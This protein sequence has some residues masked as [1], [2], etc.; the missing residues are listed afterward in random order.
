MKKLL[1]TLAVASVA[2][3]SSAATRVLY[4]QNFETVASPADAGWTFGGTSLSIAS[5]DA[6]KFLELSLGG[7]NGR[8]GIVTW[9][10][11]IFLKDGVS[12]LE[13]GTYTV[14]F[15]F[16]IKQGSNNQYNSAFTVF[17]NHKPTDNQ[18]YRNPWNPAGWWDNYLFDMSQ[19]DKQPLQF[20]VNGKTIE[21]TGDDGTVTR[22]ID[23]ST[24]STFEQ[25]QWYTVTLNVDVNTREVEYSVATFGMGDPV[26]DASGTI[27]VPENDVNG[28]PINMF[29]Q[30][31]F[32]MVARYQTIYD[33]DNIKVFYESASDYA[34]APTLALTRL[35]R[36][37]EGD[38][39]L[40]LR[41]YTITF[42]EGETLHVLGTDGVETAVEY[43]DPETPGAY[44]YEATE[45]GTLKAWTTSGE[46]TSEVVETEVDCN[47]VVLPQATATIS[48]VTA[49]FGKTYTLNVD[50]SDVPLRPTIFI[51]YEFT[52]KSGTVISKEGEA[53]GCKIT[54]DEEGTL[55]ITTQSFGY[56]EN[57]ASVV[58]DLEFEVKKMYDF[59]R[60]GDEEITKAGFPAWTVLNTSNMSGFNSWSGRK[61]LYYELA[62]SEHDNGEGVMIR[63][64]VYPFG[65]LADDNTTN[66]IKYAVI[67]N[68]AKESVNKGDVFEGLT[69]FPDKGR[70]SAGFPNVGMIRG[71][72]L[73][74]DQTNNNNNNIIV[75]D[76]DR[77]DFVVVNYINNY[78]GNSIHPVCAND[79]EYFKQL[80]GEDAVYSVAATGVLDEA[81]QT[82]S[83]THALYRVDT[84]CTK[85]TVFKQAGAQSGLEN[86]V[87]A[88]EENTDEGWYT[89]TGLRLEK[90]TA[91]GLYIHKGKKVIVK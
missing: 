7:S 74:N 49:G 58:N 57:T 63:D 62:G 13:D 48:S 52:G 28:D 37:A 86:V 81:S 24:P 21:T 88:E 70:L 14:Q 9:G 69:I 78:G 79:E 16:C 85:I 31:L 35:G 71:I 41:A 38:L 23:Y 67:D 68:S 8:S 91:P 75:N 73:Y 47:P 19:V 40:N 2:L 20:A 17:T 66:V 46:A 55:K 11:D 27:T 36:T 3:T 80:A 12:V 6:G 5:D 45:S 87:V 29:A 56:Q 89:I 51:N 54:V 61:R 59:A 82:Y 60:M 43:Y 34:N 4:E 90:P 44:V 42:L 26:S 30:G 22:A 77:N 25:N 53:S 65:Y 83:Q 18:P 15:D 32:V 33:I 72:G 84:A 76:L 64:L 39:N 10:E 1:L 50:N